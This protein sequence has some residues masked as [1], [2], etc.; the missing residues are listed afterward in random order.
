MYKLVKDVRAY[1]I[2]SRLVIGMEKVG[3]TTRFPSRQELKASDLRILVIFV[4]D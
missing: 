1:I 3:G 4:Q 2:Y